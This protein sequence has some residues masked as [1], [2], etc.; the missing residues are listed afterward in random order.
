M[1]I[2]FKVGDFAY[3]FSIIR[4][5]HLMNRNQWLPDE[6]LQ[7]FQDVRIQ[8][9]VSHA[10][11]NVPYYR[12]LFDDLGLRPRDVRTAS[13]LA[14]LPILDRDDVRR[15]GDRLHATNARRF[16]PVH[17]TT[18]G[19]T[20]DPLAILLDKGANILE[21]VYYWRHW[22]WAGYRLGDRFAEL[23]A[24]HFMSRAPI[25]HE[26]A[27]WQP[28][29]GRLMLNSSLISRRH[30]SQMAAAIRR[31]RPKFIKGVA[32]ALYYFCRCLEDAGVDNLSFDG[33]FST[34]EVLPDDFRRKI[35][36]ALRCPV[37]DSYGHMERTAAIS[38]CPEGGYHVNSDYGVLELIDRR[39]SDTP[40]TSLARPVGTSLYNMA[41]PLLRYDIGDTIEIYDNSRRCPCGR[42]LPLIKAIH[43][44]TNDVVITPDGR[45]LTTLFILQQQIEGAELVQFVQESPADLALRVVPQ[46]DWSTGTWAAAKAQVAQLVG[47]EMQVRV[48][49]VH[50]NE[51]EEPQGKRRAVISK[52][53]REPLP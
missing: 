2:D 33:A 38:Q 20:G 46:S 13:D 9:I 37:L 28:Q 24:L 35:Q 36:S 1:A 44:R 21:F 52:I 26:P 25:A 12:Q 30:V 18:S 3:P 42:T 51:I 47:P 8:T 17:H 11:R 53:S 14:R 10:Y 19:T 31:R 45:Y 16:R 40:G 29:L 27:D 6:K 32:S 5:R 41:M 50:P 34:G 48:D 7:D 22:S 43:G 49:I 23:G 4:L 39:P 15:A